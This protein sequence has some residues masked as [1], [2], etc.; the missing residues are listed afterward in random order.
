VKAMKAVKA[1]KALKTC[2]TFDD[3]LQQYF[4]NNTI[5]KV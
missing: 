5:N 2:Q 3:I 1:V 4:Q